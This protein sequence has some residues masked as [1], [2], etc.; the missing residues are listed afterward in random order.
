MEIVKALGLSGCLFAGLL[1]IAGAIIN[2]E[3]SNLGVCVTAA[4]SAVALFF[5][6]I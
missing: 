4:V 6:L 3:K 5:A 2:G 1:S